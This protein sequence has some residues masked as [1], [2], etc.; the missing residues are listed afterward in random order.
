MSQGRPDAQVCSREAGSELEG[1]EES[2]IRRNSLVEDQKD[3]KDQMSIIL[4]HVMLC[5]HQRAAL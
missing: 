4:A 5:Q 1:L 3:Q 2:L